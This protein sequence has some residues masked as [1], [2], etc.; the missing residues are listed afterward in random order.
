MS[1]NHRTVKI[2][3]LITLLFFAFIYFNCSNEPNKPITQ[4]QFDTCQPSTIHY[5]IAICQIIIVCFQTLVLIIFLCEP[6]TQNEKL[7]ALFF[8]N[9]PMTNV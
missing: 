8:N 1:R 7:F 2:S 9:Q 5:V 6:T 3:F 4:N